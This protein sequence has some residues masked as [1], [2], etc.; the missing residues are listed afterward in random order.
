MKFELIIEDLLNELSGTEIYNKYYSKIPYDIFLT[1]IKSDPKSVVNDGKIER[2]GKFAKL[3]ISLYQKGGLQLEDL[4]KAEEYLGYVYKHTM[5]IDLNKIKSLSDLYE[6][7]KQYIVRDTK[8]FDQVLNVLPKD[9]YKVLHNGEKWY[10]FQ[11]LTEKASCYLGINTEWCTTWG[12]QSLEKKHQGR[13]SMFSNYANRGPLYIMINKQDP[14]YKFQ[15]SFESSQYMDKNDKSID[16]SSFFYDKDEIFNFFFPSFSQE[17][18]SEQIKLEVKRIEILPDSEAMILIRKSIG[19]TNNQL[20]ESI[21][22]EDLDSV[23][24]LIISDKVEDIDF[25]T[26][27]R[28]GRL[29]LQMTDLQMDLQEVLYVIQ[30]YTSDSEDGYDFLHNDLQDSGVDFAEDHLIEFFKKYYESNEEEFRLNFGIKNYQDFYN[31]FYE[32]Y[33]GNDVIQDAFV[34][35]AVE[36]TI[37]NFQDATKNRL[38]EITDIIDISYDSEVDVSIVKFV[39]FL[40]KRNISKID[41]NEGIDIFSLFDSFIS[42]YS[43]PTEYEYTYDYQQNFPKFEME[44]TDLK[45]KTIEYFDNL[46]S[47]GPQTEQCHKLRL[48]LNDIIKK[49]FNGSNEYENEHY[50]V[51]I[52][53]Q[54][55]NCETGMVKIDF[56]NKDTGEVI[57]GWGKK[58]GNVKVENLVSWM[59]NYKLFESY[60]KFRKLIK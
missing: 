13:N 51:R 38:K 59:T 58:D 56:I 15:F 25:G 52:H 11:P 1:I 17:V 29:I 26:S 32:N 39:Q 44:R 18:S 47:N 33:K 22:N 2:L 19:S 50:K 9:E 41:D 14:S 37:D 46:L 35:D 23:R 16:T 53:G 42:D 10:I 34:D 7:V 20:V 4:N 21:L 5:S 43:V 24:E 55:I 40:V 8:S 28:K 60:S 57:A 49:Y 31:M 27:W 30:S 36:L 3:L 12:P 48:Q 54:S 6:L 45:E